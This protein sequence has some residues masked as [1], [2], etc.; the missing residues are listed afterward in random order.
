M[1]GGLVRIRLL[2]S[3]AGGGL[4]QWNCH[5]SNCDGA[6]AGRIPA[7]TQSS[8]A[9]SADGDAWFLINASP[10]IRPQL[11]SLPRGESGARAKPFEAILLS[12]ADLD[13]SLGLLMVR[14]GGP[15]NVYSSKEIWQTVAEA[16]AFERILG[17]FSG[18]GTAGMSWHRL[19]HECIELETAGGIPT[20]L[21]LKTHMLLGDPPSYDQSQGSGAGHACALEIN[22]ERSGAR[23]VCALDVAAPH[24]ELMNAISTADLSIVDGTFWSPA[25][26]IDLGFSTRTSAEMGHWPISGETGSLTTFMGTARKGQLVY[27]H[28]NNTN[29]I[30]DPDSPERTEVK[31]AGLI[32]GEDG[33]EWTL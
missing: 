18:R 17:A 14:E 10:D 28:I 23:V 3:A 25:E 29:P 22:D 33:M 31:A 15:V 26:M 6:R 27:S 30:L 24:P 5:C 9:F 13:H 11:E 2:G 7:R 12:N 4:P 1:R 16:L 21:R 19:D 8:V 32:I 20:G